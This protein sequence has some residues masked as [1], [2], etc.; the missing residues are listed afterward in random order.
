M[1]KTELQQL[2]SNHPALDHHLAE[3]L[4][5]LLDNTFG[6]TSSSLT[7]AEIKTAYE[8]NDDTNT[9]TDALLSK[10]NG[11]E[12]NAT[13]D[14]TGAEIRTALA[15]EADTN[16][17]TDTLLTKLN[18]IDENA[19]DDL[20]GPEIKAAYEGNGDTNAFTDAEK[21]K[22]GTV[23][24]GATPNLGNHTATQNLDMA[25]NTIVNPGGTTSL[26]PTTAAGEAI[27]PLDPAFG[28]QF[29]G[30]HAAP[31]T[32]GALSIG[33]SAGAGASSLILYQAA[34]APTLTGIVQDGVWNW[35]NTNINIILVLH[36][37]DG[38]YMAFHLG[39]HNSAA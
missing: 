24:S 35:D 29:V 27:D 30:T 34:S 9:L 8:A 6:T 4:L 21:T 31:A 16:I 11:V 14:Q 20:T 17:L 12:A 39:I 22:L 38:T 5:I 28:I 19:T 32:S 1:T 18:G 10:I 2:I 3:L 15:A 37:T 25:G 33:T 23:Q 26:D 7:N 36:H 13:A